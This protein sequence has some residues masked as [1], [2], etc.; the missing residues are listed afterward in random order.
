MPSVNG[1]LILT[2]SFHKKLPETINSM[3]V[4]KVKQMAADY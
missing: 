4:I 3:L 2:S 1:L